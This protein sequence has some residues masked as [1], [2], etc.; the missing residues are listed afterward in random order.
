M[1]NT[2]ATLGLLGTSHFASQ[3]KTIH[4]SCVHFIFPPVKHHFF[5]LLGIQGN[6]CYTRL[7]YI[8]EYHHECPFLF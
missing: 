3:S 5:C 7:Q 2:V 4:P 1:D 8:E 6:V